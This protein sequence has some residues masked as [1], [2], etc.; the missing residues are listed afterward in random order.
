MSDW[1]PKVFWTD[2]AVTGPGPGQ[3]GYGIAL[4]ARPVR[5]PSKS[6]LAVPTRACA[7][8]IAAEWRAQSGKVNPATMPH[9]RTA[10]SA[11]DKVAFAAVEVAGLLSHYAE[12]DLLCYRAE[13][14]ERLSAAQAKGW[15]PLLDW[16]H[17]TFG[18][19]LAVTAGVMP[20][21]QDPVAIDALRTQVERMDAF[22]LSAFH[23]LVSLSG[24]LVLALAVTRGRLGTE[25]AWGLSRIDEEFQIAEWGADDDAAALTARKRA[26]LEDAAL[27]F[28][29]LA[30]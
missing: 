12:T 3:T 28:S 15:D 6:R 19:R 1:A 8:L 16:A 10:N 11:I 25:D 21:P 24:S 7:E 22:R 20:V 26:A 14:P 2:V 9:T 5:T 4:D 23:D 18:A 27:F 17:E 29:A 13:A 30:G